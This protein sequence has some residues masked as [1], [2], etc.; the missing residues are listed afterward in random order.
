MTTVPS[1]LEVIFAREQLRMTS[2]RL[3][4]FDAMRSS[5]MPLSIGEIT[6][7]CS[8]ID[9]VSIYRTIDLFVQLG[10]AEAV[11]V[12]WKKQYELTS[13]FQ[14]H[15][16]HLYCSSCGSLVDIHSKKLEQIVAA[17]AR[18]YDFA[19][20]EHKFE[21]SGLCKNCRTKIT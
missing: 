19:P 11:P 16:H 2:P 9:R 10:I 15:H 8:A 20:S 21:V 14:S 7:K 12:G 6:K 5:E 13:P 18:D 1:E 3:A 4:V 17:I